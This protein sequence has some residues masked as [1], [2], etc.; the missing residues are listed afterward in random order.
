MLLKIS[1]MA[2]IISVLAL[3]LTIFNAYLT[4]KGRE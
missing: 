4:S 1:V 3:G 2:L